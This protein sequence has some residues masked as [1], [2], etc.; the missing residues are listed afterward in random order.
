MCLPK[1]PASYRPHLEFEW[2]VD[3]HYLVG[4]AVKA[5]SILPSWRGPSS[6]RPSLFT[7][8]IERGQWVPI[9]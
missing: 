1:S 2:K 8:S 3:K 7:R 6:Q 5:N 9:P 4:K